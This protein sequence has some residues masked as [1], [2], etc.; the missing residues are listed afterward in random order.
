MLSVRILRRKEGEHQVY[1]L[2]V[3][4]LE[5]HRLIQAQEHGSHPEQAFQTRVGQ[6]DACTD[7][8]RA[9]GLPGQKRIENFCGGY[10]EGWTRQIR[11]HSQ[12]L[13][14]AIGAHTVGD[15]AGVQPLVDVHGERGPESLIVTKSKSAVSG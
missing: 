14:L 6:T 10:G 4:G 9:L 13:P 2:L 15:A 5:V 7:A 12:S 11:D 8:C 1:R 3:H